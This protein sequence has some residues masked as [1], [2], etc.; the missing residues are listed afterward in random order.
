MRFTSFRFSQLLVQDGYTYCPKVYSCHL[1]VIWPYKSRSCRFPKS[2][3]ILNFLTKISFKE[4]EI[5]YS[6]YKYKRSVERKTSFIMAYNKVLFIKG[7]N[8][9]SKLHIYCPETNWNTVFT[10]HICVPTPCSAFRRPYKLSRYS[11]QGC[12]VG[13]YWVQSESDF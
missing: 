2:K 12:W 6:N 13:G 8:F 7:N 5:C 1:Q 9:Y 11:N 3:Y 10:S 4:Y